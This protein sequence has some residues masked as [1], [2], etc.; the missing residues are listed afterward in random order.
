[1]FC[2]DSHLAQRALGV[3]KSMG[4]LK[5]S[6]KWAKGAY[7]SF[8]QIDG[9]HPL[10]QEVEDFCILYD[11]RIRPGGKVAYFNF[12]LAQEM[13]LIPSDHPHKLNKMLEEKLLETFGLVIINEYDLVHGAPLKRFLIKPKKYM[14][15]RYLQL[16]HPGKQ[17]K[18]SGDGRSIWNGYFHAKGVGWD[19]SS[20]GTGA[21]RLSPATALKNKFFKS[22]DPSVSYGCGYA[23]LLDG[24]SAGLM[25]EVFHGNG[26]KT[27]RILCV[28]E[29]PGRCSVNIRTGK[30]LLRPSHFFRY[31]KQGHH[32]QLSQIVNYYIDRQISNKQWPD[33]TGKKK[34]Y[35]YLLKEM[36]RTLARVSALFEAEYIF[37]WLEWD[38]DNILMDGGIIDY[39]SV[40]QFGLYHHEYRYDDVERM[41][42]SLTEQKHKAKYIVKTFAQLVDYLKTEDKKNLREFDQHPCLQEFEQIF[43]QVK[44][45]IILKKVGFKKPYREYLFQYHKELVESF[46]YSYFY[47]ESYKSDEGL[48]KT[49]D[50]VTHNAVFCM[51]DL[52]RQYPKH[53]EGTKKLMEFEDFIPLFASSY[54]SGLDLEKSSYKV[55][56]VK[57]WQQAYQQLTENIYQKFNLSPSALYTEMLHL[58]RRYNKYA[59]ITGDSIVYIA[60]EFILYKNKI[61]FDHYTSL[62]EHFIRDQMIENRPSEKSVKKLSRHKKF[63]DKISHILIDFREGL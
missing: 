30:N 28:I 35:D 17:G 41:S 25:S 18:T 4:S 52:L 15:T 62:L 36:T 29:Y 49:E 19:I 46:L 47:F 3:R 14:A 44:H 45:D 7:S 59:R 1:M 56:H 22:G 37:C 60:K 48:V 26:I 21:T 11:I 16:Q 32:D 13:G 27:E 50:G 6:R 57:E 61:D 39:G 40:R 33:I 42:T 38:G 24:I 34:R 2:N 51:R 8:D 63:L 10:Q 31:L 9:E 53:L 20:C 54:A 12:E 58:A 23:N 5:H 55:K 43:K